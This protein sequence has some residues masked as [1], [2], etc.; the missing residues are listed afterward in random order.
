MVEHG[1]RPAGSRRRR[2]R[3]GLC[4]D[5]NSQIPPELARRYGVEVVPLTVTLDGIAYQEGVDLDAD[6]FWEAMARGVRT[7]STAAPS[8]G[9]FRIAYERL[10]EAG[11]AT[12]LSVH[13]GAEVSSTVSSA[14]LATEA[15]PVPVWVVDT[16]T[17]SFG[18]TACLWEAA[19]ALAAGASPELA[20]TVAGTVAD[21]I[22]NVFVVAG[23][24]LARRGGR[25]APSQ[26]R[27]ADTGASQGIPI[28]SLR[29][30]KME[31]LDVA[32]TLDH[33]AAA[34]A[35]PILEAAEARPQRVALGVADR[36][37]A[38]V[39][40]ELG[41]LLAGAGPAA[42]V[43]EVVRYRIGPSVGAH[44]GPGTV[45]AFYWPASTSTSSSWSQDR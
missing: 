24:D 5:S 2:A 32:R 22:E 11:A 45:G 18:V 4:T 27:D 44:T 25:L 13:P 12:I 20:A 26:G 40:A 3:V 9:L 28:L 31:T 16:G 34:L 8:P 1:T 36:T 37:G 6:A 42:G 19:E 39:L 43:V 21:S 15:F 23:L 10:E 33:T 30:G 29:G 14:R 35:A 17:A 38:A 7:V 41:R